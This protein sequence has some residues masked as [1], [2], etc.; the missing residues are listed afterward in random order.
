MDQVPMAPKRTHSLIQP[1]PLEQVCSRS[2]KCPSSPPE[3]LLHVHF[4]RQL[5]L[6]LGLENVVTHVGMRWMW[7]FCGME[8]R[9]G[10]SLSER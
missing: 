9:I 2:Q 8:G 3:T 6:Y 1:S 4:S 7:G 10:G 5:F